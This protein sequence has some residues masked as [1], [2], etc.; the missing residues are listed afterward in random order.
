MSHCKAEGSVLMQIVVNGSPRDVKPDASVA[1]LLQELDLAPIRVA[2]ELNEELVSRKDF[3]RT[4]LR[5]GDRL[6]IVT[7]VGGG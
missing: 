1:F 2:V 5:P 4:D 6:E 3:D 7:F